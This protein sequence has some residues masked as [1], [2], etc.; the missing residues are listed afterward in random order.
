MPARG[1]IRWV[2]SQR[3]RFF[4]EGR[5]YNRRLRAAWKREGYPGKPPT[6]NL[7]ALFESSVNREMD[8]QIRTG[9]DLNRTIAS[10]KRFNESKRPGSTKPVALDTGEV[11]PEYFVRERRNQVAQENHRRNKAKR[12]LYPDWDELDAVE[13]ATAMANKN[14]H[15]VEHPPGWENPL[16][17]LG[18]FGVLGRSD[19]I[20][21][22]RYIDSP[23]TP[24]T[25]P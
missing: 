5:A 6:V 11:V 24:M 20:Y 15:P 1:K 2:A 14:L 8:S 18:K 23:C 3:E 7:T 9:A 16:D 13:R 25:L 10:W 21:S 22:V 19:Q 12:N 4:R 17:K